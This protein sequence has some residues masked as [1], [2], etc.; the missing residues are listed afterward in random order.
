[1]IEAL[2]K[3]YALSDQGARDLFKGIVYSV[4]A[5]ISLMLPVI[6][7]A[8]VL[9]QL[10]AP[11]L[12]TATQEFSIIVYTGIGIVILAAVFILHYLQYTA[13]YMGTYAESARRRIRLAEKLRT[14]PLSFFHQRDLSD[15]TSTIMGDC[16]SFE[17]AFSHT[18][19][20]FWGA[21]ISTVIVCV[22]LLIFNWQMGLALLWVA[23]ISFAIVIL[24][25]KWQEKLGKKH[26]GAR[27]ELAEGI[28][29]CLE[30][31]QDIKACNQ[32]EDYLKKLDAK[33]DAAE[34][35]QVS[36]EL[37]TAS[38]LTTGQMFLRL[39]LA[40]VIVV[41]NGLVMKGQ[42]SLFIY[43]LYLIAASRLY[44]PLSGAMSNM[45]EMFSVGL[46]VNRLKEIEEYPEEA[47]EKNIHTNGYDITFD[48]V[49]FSYEKG[50]S[51]L[52]DVSFTAKQGQ[53]TAL[54]GPSGGGKS[55]AAKL[56]AKFYP[57]ES[58]KILLG[59]T[60]I[61]PLDS[62]MLMKDFSIVFQDVV[63]FNNTIMENIRVGRKNA[64]DEDV[65]AAAKAAMCHEFIE[66]LPQ[67]YQ[68]VIGEN[69]STLS[70]GECQRLSIARA[71]LKDAPVILLDE[72]TASLDVDNETEI[73][74]AISKLVQGKTVLVI[75]HR[76][77]TIE[78]A[79]QIIVLANGIVAESGTHSELMKKNGLYRRLVDLQTESANWKLSV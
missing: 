49:K 10:L 69:G 71:L 64:T 51:V 33:M 14:L 46:Q 12:G 76:M 11:L 6:L 15:L 43:I 24:S 52:Q 3:K 4:L 47:G 26:M 28:Q 29:E 31:V 27:L 59:G 66:R 61:A 54:V 35:A 20:Q 41:G 62:T 77:R 67:G 68:T 2:K 22:G 17:H 60:D 19:P 16:A 30:T 63:L 5:N 58:G 48:H 57:L 34:K 42:T 50:K 44:D 13:A 74:N 56:A 72:A 65:I 37:A 7:L 53:V 23:P 21:V 75:A 73:Q 79:D 32:E 1:M 36:S 55:T 9:N 78:A 39:G 70:G 45:A 8:I 38:L 25:R 18:V 40:T